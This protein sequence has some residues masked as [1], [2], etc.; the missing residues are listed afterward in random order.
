MLQF[1]YQLHL[2]LKNNDNINFRYAD[3]TSIVLDYNDVEKFSIPLKKINTPS[4]LEGDMDTS[5][6]SAIK[7]FSVSFNEIE[8][9]LK[10][11]NHKKNPPKRL[12]ELL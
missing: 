2:N 6:K 7:S 1:K 5:N 4:H 12:A 8:K 11:I 10:E 9:K 3:A